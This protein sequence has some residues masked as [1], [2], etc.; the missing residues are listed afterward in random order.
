MGRGVGNPAGDLCTLRIRR[1]RAERLV[2]HRN[3]L[4]RVT[5]FDGPFGTD[6]LRGCVRDR[7][8]TGGNRLQYQELKGNSPSIRFAGAAIRHHSELGF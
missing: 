7:C 4:A 3:T 2:V 5:G 6:D 8:Q 1:E